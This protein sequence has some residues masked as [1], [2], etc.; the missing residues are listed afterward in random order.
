M[1]SLAVDPVHDEIFVT[2]SF[3]Q[4]VLAFRGSASGE[5]APVRIIQGPNTKLLRAGRLAVD[6]QHDEL[7]VCGDQAILVFRRDANGDV[8]PL[9]AIYG[10]KTQITG[11]DPAV[12]V[13]PVN[14]VIVLYQRSGDR[15]E[16]DG[17]LLLFRRTDDGDVAPQAVIGGPKTGLRDIGQIQVYSPRREI[18]VAMP[19]HGE[20]GPDQIH[21]FIGVWSLDDRGD[22]PPRAV[23]R[24][25]NTGLMRPRGLAINPQYKEI[26]VTDMGRNALFTFS[27]PQIF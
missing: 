17:S 3:A 26:L 20:R 13:D 10:P 19:G 23:I 8:E 21:G 2:N 4:A 16:G 11:G 12:A 14:D 22:A 15:E 27:L 5:E 6:P 1:H 25:P 24:G 7:I 9:R 18:I